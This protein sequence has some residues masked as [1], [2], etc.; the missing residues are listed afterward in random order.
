MKL[1]GAAILVSRGMKVLQAAPAAYPYRSA[2]KTMGRCLPG[3]M[4]PMI[5]HTTMKQEY[6]KIVRDQRDCLNTTTYYLDNATIARI[7][8]VDP[9]AGLFKISYREAEPPYDAALEEHCERYSGVM[10]EFVTPAVASDDGLRVVKVQLFK[11]KVLARRSEAYTDGNGRDVKIIEF[12]PDGRRL[13]ER[14]MIYDK[15]GEWIGTKI[16]DE[17][18]R[19]KYDNSVDD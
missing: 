3:A 19:F 9:K 6:H 4:H 15:N 10:A 5:G 16:Y 8:F 11:G 17:D 1:T 12:T 18:G 14:H 7:D 2:T 13:R